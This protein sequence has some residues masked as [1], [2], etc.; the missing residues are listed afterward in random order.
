[1]EGF[2]VFL[3]QDFSGVDVSHQVVVRDVLLRLL[4]SLGNGLVGN[5][6]VRGEHVGAWERARGC[7]GWEERI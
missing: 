4:E 2:I 1:M 7:V 3:L 6:W 5:T